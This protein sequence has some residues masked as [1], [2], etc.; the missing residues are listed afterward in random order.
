M[1]ETED[2]K[3]GAAEP[4][5][6]EPA[7]VP[8]Q[9][10]TSAQAMPSGQVLAEES[11]TKEPETNSEQL[12]ELKVEVVQELTVPPPESPRDEKKQ[13]AQEPSGQ[14]GSPSDEKK[15]D[16]HG[17]SGQVGEPET[18]KGLERKD[19]ASDSTNKS[20]YVEILLDAHGTLA[21]GRF[22][23]PMD[24][25]TGVLKKLGFTG[26]NPFPTLR[27]LTEFLCA[28]S[29]GLP[30]GVRVARTAYNLRRFLKPK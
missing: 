22:F 3:Q 8:A 13:D 10:Q 14:V 29:Y 12:A 27:K 20:G 23:A 11:K 15:Q 9:T 4:L 25:R 6:V 26:P 2:T 18:E 5:Q 1:A 16:A 19:Q 28:D 7:Q 30:A 21:V 17:P 24:S